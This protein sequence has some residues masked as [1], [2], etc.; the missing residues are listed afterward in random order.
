MNEELK[1]YKCKVKYVITYC[2]HSKYAKNKF[3]AGSLNNK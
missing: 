3:I 1:I 2:L